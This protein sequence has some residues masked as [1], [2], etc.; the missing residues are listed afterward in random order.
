MY[1][2]IDGFQLKF[3]AIIAMLINHIGSGFEIY[4]Y[5]HSLFF[6]TE[7]IGKLTFPIMAYLLVEGFH[8]TKNVKKYALRL[9]VFWL[10]SIYPFHAWFYPNYPFDPT[11]LVNNIFFTLLMG[12][13]LIIFYE[14]TKNKELHILLV[15]VFSLSTIMS[16]WNLIG[17]LMIYGF[18]L[19]KD[20][21][22]K[23]IVPPIYTTLFLFSL[24]LI[25]YI[26]TPDSVPWYELVSV[27]G[28]LGVIPLLL[29][30]NGQRGYSPNW[31]KWGFYLF[32]PLHLI[33]LIIIRGLL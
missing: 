12:L 1:K 18:Y 33:V 16:D 21:T 22:M 23:K 32:Y 20:V 3:I 7:L 30:Y 13:L 6:L 29:N 19:I 8:Y 2:K 11:E 15:L 14:K 9:T 28:I 4:N 24:M 26:I 17:V 31:V 25:A 10:I 27:F 5:S